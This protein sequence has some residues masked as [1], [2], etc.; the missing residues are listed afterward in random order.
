MLAFYL[1]LMLKFRLLVQVAVLALKMF[2]AELRVGPAF[3]GWRNVKTGT[4]KNGK[5]DQNGL[6]KDRRR[7]HHHYLVTIAYADGE[8]FG[9]VYSS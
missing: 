6:G 7:K 5:K 4:K 9:R 2:P 3:R 8:K 1:P